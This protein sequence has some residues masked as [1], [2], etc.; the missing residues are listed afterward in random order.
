MRKYVNHQRLPR[1][2][3]ATAIIAMLYLVLFSSLAVGFVAATNTAVQVAYNDDAAQRA[4]LAAESGVEFVSFY[5]GR[6]NVDKKTAPEDMMDVVFN[7]L[8]IM[9]NGSPNL[10]GGSISLVND[11][12]QIPA[13][14][15]QYVRVNDE[16]GFGRFRASIEMKPLAP[17][18][19]TDPLP[20]P[21]LRVK[22][23]GYHKDF[24]SNARGI[25][26]DYQIETKRGKRFQFGVASKGPIILR[27]NAQIRG[28]NDHAMGSM[29][30]TTI[31]NPAVSMAGNPEQGIRGFVPAIR[32]HVGI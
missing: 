25:M 18:T 8:G 24:S 9:L 1:R 14:P 27:S 16:S 11:V 29:L 5:L 28:L 17:P 4:I 6:L 22:V 15:T 13:D 23:A 21:E 12:I 20:V 26:L 10:A 31:Q 32:R 2:R 30:T 19:P 7:Q 3:G